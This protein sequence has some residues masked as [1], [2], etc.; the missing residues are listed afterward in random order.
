MGCFLYKN[1]RPTRID[2][3][4]W[5][6]S[7]QITAP[8][9]SAKNDGCLCTFC[10]K[11][12]PG[13]YFSWKK[14][15]PDGSFPLLLFVKLTLSMH[16]YGPSKDP[17]ILFLSGKTNQ[18]EGITLTFKLIATI[19]PRSRLR[20]AISGENELQHW[21]IEFSQTGYESR[22]ALSLPLFLWR[23]KE[24]QYF[25]CHHVGSENQKWPYLDRC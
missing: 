20:K 22:M 18:P 14:I 24:D 9:T 6:I 10:S 21:L 7:N 23:F 2:A 13:V 4:S 5:L 8:A 1:C 12:T 17:E 11:S 25:G 3:L 19:T 15:Y 16:L